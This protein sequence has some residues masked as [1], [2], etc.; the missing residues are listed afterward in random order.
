MQ[1][2]VSGLDTWKQ[3]GSQEGVWFR[4]WRCFPR[5]S[6]ISW[7]SH[8]GYCLNVCTPG[9]KLMWSVGCVFF[10]CKFRSDQEWVFA[11]SLFNTCMDL[12]E[13]WTKV[14]VEHLFAILRPLTLILPMTLLSLRIHWW[15]LL[16]HCPRKLNHWNSKCLGSNTKLQGSEDLLDKMV[17]FVHASGENILHT[18]LGVA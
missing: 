11:P 17:R 15:F 12:E 5:S 13:P 6:E 7:N 16:R 10:F 4:K 18:Y 2:W 3:C 9:P 14:I 1:A 8:K